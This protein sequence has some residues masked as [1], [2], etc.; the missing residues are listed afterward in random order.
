MD[1]TPVYVELG[2]IKGIRTTK[3]PIEFLEQDAISALMNAPNTDKKLERR[4]QMLIISLYDTAA[5]VSEALNVRLCD[6]HL[7]ASIPYVILLGKGRK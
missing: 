3:L 6:L 4:N 7:N 2:T 1:I 5:R